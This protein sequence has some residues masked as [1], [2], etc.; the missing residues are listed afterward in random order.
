MDLTQKLQSRPDLTDAFKN[1]SSE[2]RVKLIETHFPDLTEEKLR[3][4][5]LSSAELD[6]STLRTVSG[7]VDPAFVYGVAKDIIGFIGGGSTY[8]GRTGTGRNR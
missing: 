3:S 2:E 1:A 8:S 7:G 6:E 4:I 5:D